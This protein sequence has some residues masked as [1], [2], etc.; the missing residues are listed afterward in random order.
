MIELKIKYIPAIFPDYDFQ[1]KKQI[2]YRL[3]ENTENDN[4]IFLTDEKFKTVEQ[5]AKSE[6]RLIQSHTYRVFDCVIYFWLW[7]SKSKFRIYY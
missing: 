7:C 1:D 5:T 6:Q 4:T 2:K 3:Y